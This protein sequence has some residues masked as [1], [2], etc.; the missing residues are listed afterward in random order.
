MQVEAYAAE[1]RSAGRKEFQSA[2]LQTFS[3]YLQRPAEEEDMR[4]WILLGILVVVA[5]WGGWALFQ[6]HREAVWLAAYKHATQ[7]F[8]QEVY[9]TAEK[10]FPE[11]LREAK[12]CYPKDYRLVALPSRR[13]PT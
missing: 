4:R 6:R 5:S 2:G 3:L 9:A 10:N 11:I 13:G 8:Y 1:A 12:K 7:A